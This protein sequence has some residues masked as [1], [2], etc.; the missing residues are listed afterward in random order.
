[1]N[2]HLNLSMMLCVGLAAGWMLHGVPATAEGGGGQGGGVLVCAAKNGDAN[3]DGGVN[4]SDAVTLLN[5][6]F[7][8]NPRELIPL[9]GG[10]AA[11]CGLPDTGET[12]CY[13][14]SGMELLR[15]R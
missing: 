5:F 7:L 11:S 10:S 1:M 12:R 2:R 4:L 8:G 14:E 9:C 6:L 13:D 15:D 3:A